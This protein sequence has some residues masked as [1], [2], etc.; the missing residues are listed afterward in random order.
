[1]VRGRS[2][3]AVGATLVVI[4]G[5][6]G[7]VLLAPGASAGG[8]ATAAG[9]K[10][11]IKLGDN[12]FKPKKT[13]AKK[14][15]RVKFRWTGSNSHNVTL[16]KGPGK[17]FAS[18]TTSSKGVNFSRKFKKRGTYKMF[19]TIHPTTMKVNLKVR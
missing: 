17:K 1:M 8:D 16:R 14:G 11:T 19:C 12:F 15:T 9:K 2:R 6:L 5:L 10:K 4:A 13:S 7:A 18:G 3:F